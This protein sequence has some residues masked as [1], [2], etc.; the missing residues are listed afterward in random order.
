MADSVRRTP[1]PLYCSNLPNDQDM[2][3]ALGSLATPM[4]LA[5]GDCLFYGVGEDGS[6]LCVCVE[7]KKVGDMAQC[8]TDGR[9]VHQAQRAKSAGMDVL[10]LIVEGP[11]RPDPHDGLLE[12]LL[13]GVD[14]QT[15]R[16][17]SHWG[18]VRPALTYSRWDQYLTELDWLAGV[19]V[20]RSRDVR[21]TAAIIKALWSNFQT[22]SGEHGSLHQMFSP[23]PD[24][25]LLVPPNLVRRVARELKGIGWGRSREIAERFPTVAA[26]VEATVEDWKAIP[27]VGE[28]LA[29]S[30]V[31]ELHGER[32]GAEDGGA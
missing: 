17:R 30:V 1:S 4:P 18:P 12:T 26:M 9:Y 31:D 10:I 15:M 24:Q 5:V 21:E 23:P 13:W 19:V 27:G 6:P 25:M 29:R 8:I 22:P 28:K 20:K 16:R 32:R 7:R 3:R 2:I 11:A 14:P